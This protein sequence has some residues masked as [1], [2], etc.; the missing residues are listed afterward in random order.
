M[1]IGIE[2]P[3]KI[4]SL[5]LENICFLFGFYSISLFSAFVKIFSEILFDFLSGGRKMPPL[6]KGR[7]HAKRDG[8]IVK[9]R[10]E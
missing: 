8:G 10:F 9:I 2:P 7:W 3:I 1:D 5:S 6:C 4:E